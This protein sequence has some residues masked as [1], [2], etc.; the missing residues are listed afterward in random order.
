MINK[1]RIIKIVTSSNAFLWHI[2]ST[3]EH[4]SDKYDIYIIGNDLEKYKKQFKDVRFININIKRK[5][6]L[7]KDLVSLISLIYY[8]IKIKPILVHSIM[9]KSGLLTAISGFIARVP[10]RLHT[11]TGQVWYTK[12]GLFRYILKSLDKLIIMLNTECLADSL[13]QAKYLDS[14]LV[15]NKNKELKVINH[16][17]ICGI[18]LNQVTKVLH[19]NNIRKLQEIRYKYDINENDFVFCYMARKT[20]DKGAI[21]IIDAFNRVKKEAKNKLIKLLYIGPY[22]ENINLTLRQTFSFNQI[23]DIGLV[24]NPLDYLSISNV[25]CL[26]SYREGFGNVIID[27]AALGIPSIG[28]DIIGLKDS[29]IHEKTGIAC[30]VGNVEMFSKFML[31]IMLDDKYR[32]KLANQSKKNAHE[33]FSSKD[34]SKGYEKFYNHLIKSVI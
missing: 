9:P 20:R 6:A 2:S 34:L 8:F 19:G 4:L 17:S 28:Y 26:P 24:K 31:K 32:I 16:G 33:K 11:F 14:Q 13:S 7:F 25:F 23:V 10:I 3:L 30:P 12:K 1:H 18:N 5:P 15:K 21:D 27:A 29:I 22:E